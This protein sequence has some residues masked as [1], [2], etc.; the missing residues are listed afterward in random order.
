V[1]LGNANIVLDVETAKGLTV[2]NLSQLEIGD[3]GT[4]NLLLSAASFVKDVVLL[5][6]KKQVLL[7]SGL[8]ERKA[9]MKLILKLGNCSPIYCVFACEYVGI[10]H[11]RDSLGDFEE[12]V[13]LNLEAYERYGEIL[14]TD[15]IVLQC[16]FIALRRRIN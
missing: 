1:N 8:E 6:V 9:L 13:C 2:E 16:P 11:S 7:M 5:G 14:K 12:N 4:A 15:F 3:G 10:F